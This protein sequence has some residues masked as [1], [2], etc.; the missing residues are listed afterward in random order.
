[1]SDKIC[2]SANTLRDIRCHRRQFRWASSAPCHRQPRFA[3]REPDPQTIIAFDFVYENL[4]LD[5][6]NGARSLSSE[7]MDTK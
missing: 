6:G 2:K 3:H 7:Q 1:M 4:M 5:R